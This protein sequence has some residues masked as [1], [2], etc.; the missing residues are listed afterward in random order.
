MSLSLV[1][2]MRDDPDFGRRFTKK[3]EEVKQ[4]KKGLLSA[5]EEYLERYKDEAVSY[6]HLRAHETVLDI[7][8]RLLLEKTNTTLSNT[9]YLPLVT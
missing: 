2:L 3:V 1:T 7:V 4:D 9:T 5:A 8:C 6:T